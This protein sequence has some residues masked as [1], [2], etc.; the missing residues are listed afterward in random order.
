MPIR[1][2]YITRDPDVG[3][4][5]QRAGVDWIFVDMEYRG[6]SARQANRNTVISA[7]TLEDVRAMR[8][9]IRS[10]QLIVRLNPL[11]QWSAKEICGV[12]EAGADIVMLP[13][14][15]TAQEVAIFV[16]LVGGETKTCLLLETLEAID[17][18][19]E[20]LAVTGIDYVH[21]GLNDI[22]IARG[23]TFM[24]EFL[25]DGGVDRIA[26]KLRQSCKVFGFGGMARIGELLPPAEHILAEHFRVGSTG[27]ILSRSFCNPDQA[28]GSTAF[29]AMFKAQVAKIREQ[30]ALFEQETPEFFERNRL[31]VVKE[32]EDV[33]VRI[34][35]N[36]PAMSSHNGKVD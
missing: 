15:K 31:Q 27:V 5:A 14:F 17:A 6:K 1:L 2:L 9:V 12:K 8:V 20:I 29:E 22:H 11:G 32:V 10:S 26:A 7:H 34:K 25:A 18:L 36:V 16:D 13:F 28:I 19:D 21:I 4:I 30:E 33:V 23:T 3:A 35:G 24:F